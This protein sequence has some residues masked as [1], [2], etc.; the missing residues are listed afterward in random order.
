MRL[1]YL[2]CLPYRLGW[3]VEK[4]PNKIGITVRRGEQRLGT[5]KQTP[6]QLRFDSTVLGPRLVLLQPQ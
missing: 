3:V 5:E 1:F 4:T 2:Y 6:A